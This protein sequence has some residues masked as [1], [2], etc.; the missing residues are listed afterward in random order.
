MAFTPLLIDSVHKGNH[1]R[2]RGS[3]P[4][5]TKILVD[6]ED[7]YDGNAQQRTSDH[8]PAEYQCE[9]KADQEKSEHDPQGR[10]D[11]EYHDINL[12]VMVNAAHD[13]IGND[14]QAAKSN[15]VAISHT[16]EC[17]QHDMSPS[18]RQTLH[19]THYQRINSK[20]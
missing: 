18:V 17:S 3:S 10:S 12:S 13:K 15:D 14:C 19:Q 6:R 16:S 7:R 8:Q 9:S 1:A 4:H 2:D 20:P 11:Y 5:E